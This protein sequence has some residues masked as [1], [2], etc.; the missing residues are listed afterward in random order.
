[1][2]PD[3]L[4]LIPALVSLQHLIERF[5]NQG[6]IIGGVALSLL[7]RPRFTADVDAL[8]LVDDD[9]IP[10]LIGMAEQ[11]G[12]VPRIPDALAFAQ[13]QRV[14]LLQHR[15]SSINVDI[16]L[17]LLLFEIEAVGRSQ[18]YQIATLSLRLPTPEDLIIFKAV[19]HRPKDL[20]DIQTMIECYPHLDTQYIAERVREFAQLLEMPKV[21]DDIAPWLRLAQF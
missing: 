11:E 21:S 8:L 16:A 9:D 15:D 1:M 5:D 13:Q 6:I 20:L 10:H 19:A 12:L 18:V 14:L 7:A 2:T 4:S 3:L 17:G